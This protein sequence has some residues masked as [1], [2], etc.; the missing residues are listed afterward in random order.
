VHSHYD[1]YDDHILIHNECVF[2]AISKKGSHTITICELF[3]LKIVE[4]KAKASLIKKSN[5]SELIN[6]IMNSSKE[7]LTEAMSELMKRIKY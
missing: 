5:E 6:L 1:K 2:E 4:K 7:E 3:R